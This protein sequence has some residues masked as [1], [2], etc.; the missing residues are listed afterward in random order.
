M[1]VDLADLPLCVDDSYN[2]LN[3]IKHECSTPTYS[4]QDISYSFLNETI[5]VNK[6][7]FVRAHTPPPT[8]AYTSQ[9]VQGAV[10]LK[11]EYITIMSGMACAYW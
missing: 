1:F 8:T 2:D 5:P 6:Q 4:M 7:Y 3:P 9:A 10:Q 11:L